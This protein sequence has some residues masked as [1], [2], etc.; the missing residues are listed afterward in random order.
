M[1]NMHETIK[2][3]EHQI[4]GITKQRGSNSPSI[5]FF[6]A[7]YL[8]LRKLEKM[9]TGL[10]TPDEPISLFFERMVFEGL[11]DAETSSVVQTTLMEIGWDDAYANLL[12]I[13]ISDLR[14][15][16]TSGPSQEN[17]F[18]GEHTTPQAICDLSAS[19]GK[20]E[21]GFSVMDYC[22]GEGAFLAHIASNMEDVELNGVEINE[23]S[24]AIARIKIS[25]IN[26]SV[27][28]QIKRSNLFDEEI[29]YK[30]F[31]CIFSN[32]PFG[33]NVQSLKGSSA[34]LY[35]VKQ[36]LPEYRRPQSADWVFNR[37]MIDSLKD[38]GRA[39][40]VMPTGVTL[41]SRDVQVRQYFVNQGLIEGVIALPANLFSY[42]SIPV[43]LIVLSHNNKGVRFVDATKVFHKGRK[44]NYLSQED[45]SEILR[46]YET[47]GESSKFVSNDD[48]AKSDYDLSAEFRVKGQIE[49]DNAVPL[50]E[51]C[52]SLKRGAQ[53]KSSDLEEMSCKEV[54]PYRYLML[55]DISDGR[56]SS[57]LPFLKTIDKKLEKYCIETGDLLI[58]KNGSP[59][60]IAVANVEDGCKIL[61][62]GNLY[63]V[64]VN[65]NLVEPEYLA[66]FLQS[67]TGQALLEQLSTGAF[68]TSI[69][70]AKLRQLQIAMIPLDQQ[71]E[72][73]DQ[74]NAR[75]DQ[76]EILKMKLRLAREEVASLFE[77]EA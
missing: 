14:D 20:I 67:K 58:S 65:K 54:T 46:L 7:F 3:I 31:D 75:L 48:I 16:L 35:R 56:I 24:A 47:D 49:I 42:T 38:S 74:Y 19:L 39:I 17:I 37:L 73:I 1:K 18:S 43:S 76:I 21:P 28:C 11:C 60:K 25:V 29:P 59:Y 68:I 64:K 69:P 15:Y 6:V 63:I 50:E 66:I 22:C 44:K 45:V 23:I 36:G 71:H 34:Y 10:E 70:L 55:K 77:K 51:L 41:S 9:E 5:S 61:A 72:M 62:N 30:K 4:L 32:Y 40:G 2:G 52:V 26:P 53:L 27:R 12:N 8:Y 13:D 33:Y 57:E